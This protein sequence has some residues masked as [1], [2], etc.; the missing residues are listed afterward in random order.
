MR[1]EHAP[2]ECPNNKRLDIV[3]AEFGDHLIN[4]A[5]QKRIVSFRRPRRVADRLAQSASRPPN[6]TCLS[7]PRPGSKN[8]A[9]A[10]RTT[11]MEIENERDGLPG[12]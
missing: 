4:N 2:C 7:N 1:R 8:A 12:L 3:A 11:T 10:N 5:L 6:D 9:I